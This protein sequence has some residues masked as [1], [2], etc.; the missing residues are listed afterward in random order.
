MTARIVI[1]ARGLSGSTGRLHREFLTQL[2]EIDQSTDYHIIIHTNDQGAWVPTKQNYTLHVVGW[3]FYSFGEQIGFARYLYSLKP[4]LVH[5]MWP[6]QPLLYFGKRISN[7]H[8]LTLLRFENIDKNRMVYKFEKFVFRFLLHNVVRRSKIILVISNFVKK[9]LLSFAR[10]DANK[11][12]VAKLAAFQME[13][14]DRPKPI[15]RL[16]GKQFIFFVGNAFPHK[17]LD[18]LIEATEIL[19]QKH[20]DLQVA[21]AGKKDFFHEQLEQHCQDKPFAH[22]LGYVDDSELSWLYKHAQAYVFPSLSEGFGLPGLEAMQHGV[23]L[24]S[25]NATCL[26][27][28]YGDAAHYFDPYS[29]EDM[30]RAIHEVLRSQTRR[31]A[32]IKAGYE[33]VDQFSWEKMAR[34]VHSQYKK[35]LPGVMSDEQITNTKN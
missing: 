4:D 31:D 18:R 12:V 5:F 34:T 15:K 29:T 17:N 9:D 23:P 30:A 13:K 8:D 2:E 10:V 6:Q 20:P 3:K 28:I 19:R 32:L 22:I 11:I 26:P 25:S 1:D 14:Q 24:V 16:K 35:L 21:I 33:R 7:V 27:E